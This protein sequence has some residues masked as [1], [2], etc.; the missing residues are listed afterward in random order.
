MRPAPDSI[1]P[2]L[3]VRWGPFRPYGTLSCLI[4]S[5]R[6]HACKTTE[7]TPVRREALLDPWLE[8]EILHHLATL[9]LEVL[10]S[11]RMS[12]VRSEPIGRNSR[13]IGQG[14]LLV[15]CLMV[16]LVSSFLISESALVQLGTRFS[17]V[18]TLSHAKGSA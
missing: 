7:A 15:P 6:S 9:A 5:D 18:V 4:T 3:M 17:L 1:L 16:L 11:L 13:P 2:R 12:T 10:G 14:R 8:K